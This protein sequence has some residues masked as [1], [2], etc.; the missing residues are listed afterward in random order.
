[1]YLLTDADAGVGIGMPALVLVKNEHYGY[2]KSQKNSVFTVFGFCKKFQKKRC[3]FRK[4][5]PPEALLPP[6]D[7]CELVNNR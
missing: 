7:E 4:I 5:D 2:T 6:S 1:M 3:F